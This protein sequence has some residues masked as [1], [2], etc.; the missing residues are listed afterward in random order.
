M[1]DRTY[2]KISKK[3]AEMNIIHY[4][5]P[6]VY[7]QPTITPIWFSFSNWCKAVIT[8]M[9]RLSLCA[10][11]L[12]FPFTETMKLKI[13]ALWWHLCM[14][15]VKIV[16]ELENFAPVNTCVTDRHFSCTSAHV[17]MSRIP[18]SSGV[19]ILLTPSCASQNQLC[20]VVFAPYF[21]EIIKWFL[22]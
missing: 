11:D 3:Y 12:R 9:F 6:K 5:W 15:R 10:V 8:Q 13:Y 21:H 16:L 18:P 22:F 20:F 1:S 2:R 7:E 4:V 19:H 17:W 14:K